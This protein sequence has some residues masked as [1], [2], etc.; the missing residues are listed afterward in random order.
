[1]KIQGIEISD[2]LISS[3]ADR[4]GEIVIEV[5]GAVVAGALTSEVLGELRERAGT[6]IQRIAAFGML[7]LRASIPLLNSGEDERRIIEE[8]AANEHAFA[9]LAVGQCLAVLSVAEGEARDTM[10]KKIIPRVLGRLIE[11]FI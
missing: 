9:V 1:M 6:A 7:K 3:V 5:G 8:Q 4:F 2:E 11:G 10:T